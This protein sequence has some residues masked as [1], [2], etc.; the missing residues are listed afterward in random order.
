MSKRFP[1]DKIGRFPAMCTLI[2]DSRCELLT[3]LTGKNGTGY[4]SM[5]TA[6]CVQ[7]NKP[8][9]RCLINVGDSTLR[10]LQQHR[11]KLSAINTIIITSLAP[12]NCSG[13]SGVLL[14]LSDLGVAKVKIIGPAGVDILLHTITPFTNR[15]YPNVECIVINNQWN[16]YECINI[17]P[18]FAIFAKP[19]YAKQNRNGQPV[20]ISTTIFPCR[21]NENN[22]VRIASGI[23]IVPVETAFKL[24]PSSVALTK[25]IHDE[26]NS[27]VER[28][29]FAPVSVNYTNY[30]DKLVT[31]SLASIC[32]KLKIFGIY[33]SGM[34]DNMVCELHQSQ[35]LI[36]SFRFVN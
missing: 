12:H 15:K 22:V 34:L 25:H 2:G 31:K 13:L 18:C 16:C 8:T 30:S 11:V 10:I 29:L 1:V 4:C 9:G 35:K 24:Y 7:G 3:L 6:F 17:N 19:V 21:D 26:Y 36:T 33:T 28:I 5:V 32:N 14:S 27:Q 23:T 20:A